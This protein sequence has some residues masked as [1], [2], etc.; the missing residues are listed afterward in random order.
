MKIYIERLRSDTYFLSV[1]FGSE[2]PLFLGVF[3]LQKVL[4]LS[5]AEPV[6]DLFRGAPQLLEAV[7]SAIA[8]FKKMVDEKKPMTSEEI[9]L[10]G[11]LRAAARNCRVLRPKG[12]NP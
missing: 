4:F 12:E 10:F 3:E 11:Q 8:H 1:S 7:D 9:A 2:V 6:L 5:Q